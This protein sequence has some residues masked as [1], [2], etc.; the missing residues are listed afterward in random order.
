MNL[1][2]LGDLPNWR[3]AR[4]VAIDCETRD[5]DLR[6]LGPGVRRGG[7]IT[8]ISFAI[9]R[10]ATGSPQCPAFY[11]PIRHAG[12][13]NYDDPQR[14]FD[15]L[16]AQAREF[17][18]E[19]VGANLPYDL[20]Y[21]A[22][23]GVEFEPSYFRDVQVAGA[24]LMQPEVEWVPDKQTGQLYLA[25]KFVPMNLDALAQRAGL[26]GKD[27]AGLI[28]WA[29]NHGLDPK[30]DMWRAPAGIVADYAIQDA[31]LPL[32]VLKKQ[33]P[34]LTEQGLTRIWD[35]E[36]ELLPMLVEMRRRGVRVDLDRVDQIA[37][38]ATKK[39]AEAALVIGSRSGR[40]FDPAD[41]N[42]AAV[43]AEHLAADGIVC[44]KTPTGKPSVKSAWLDGLSTPVAAAIKECRKWTKLRDTFCASIRTHAIRHGNQHRIHC[45]F[46]QLRQEREDGTTKGVGF[47][48]LS[49]D[50]PNL[51]QQPAR[52]KVIGPLWRAIYLPDDGGEW[53]CIDI[54][55]Q[56]PRWIT[57][58]AEACG[59]EAGAQAAELCRTDPNW[60]NHSM[61]AGMIYGDEYSH[62]AYLDDNEAAKTKR[63]NAKT[64]FL[65][66]C[67]G[68]GGGKLCTQLGLPT[69]QVVKDPNTTEW[70]VHEVHTEEAKKLLRGGARPFEMAGAEG[71]AILDAF[72]RGV[73]YVRQLTKLV[74][75]K[76]SRVGFVQTILG[77]RCRLPRH[78]NTGKVIWTHKALNRLIQGSGA[79]Q[80]KL[81]MVWARRAGIPLQLQVHDEID[82]T[83]YDPGQLR[84]MAEIMQTCVRANV[85][86][87]TDIETGPDW[88]HIK[89]AA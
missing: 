32:R 66:R 58:Y 8:G 21:L 69:I 89:I 1:T 40:P 48:R 73:P 83:F 36:S 77:R 22:E 19:I 67:Y 75:A 74:Q 39:A 72:D 11:L 5:D 4:R 20:D 42:R 88:G 28:Q 9:D 85:P 70:V 44:P 16:R 61:M 18:G 24:L 56:E 2:H 23:E 82:F 41:I 3:G 65:G 34:Q 26:P 76:A 6:T 29:E 13:G 57:H 43:I 62:Q 7:Y 59:F 10:F 49:S 79:D 51:Q 45:T 12:G 52:D 35:I 53:G 14:V 50:A 33:I 17:E 31:R 38:M 80:M 46:N 68:M 15:Y 63:S 55:S 30:K 47:G 60:D 81:A 64:I 78:P 84:V 71:Q 27:E 87:P 37:E 86:F 54:S 25:E